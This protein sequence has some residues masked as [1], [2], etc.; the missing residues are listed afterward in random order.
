MGRAAALVRP[1]QRVTARRMRVECM[2]NFEGL[3]GGSELLLL[4][5][6]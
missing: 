3:L 2:F 5:M 6:S 4:L 1:R